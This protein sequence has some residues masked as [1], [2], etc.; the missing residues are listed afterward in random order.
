L[1]P[2][3]SHTRG[4]I[5]IKPLH[6]FLSNISGEM[7]IAS[8]AIIIL[9]KLLKVDFGF[10]LGDRKTGTKYVVVYTAIFAGVTLVCHMLM[11]I[12][13]MLP[14]IAKSMKNR[15]TIMTEKIGKRVGRLKS[16][17]PS[18]MVYC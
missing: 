13:D 10:G 1:W 4:L 8:A 2:I 11:L 3:Y 17:Y 16:K 7:L 18:I 15:N 5:P 9:S 14:V 12:Y 6:G